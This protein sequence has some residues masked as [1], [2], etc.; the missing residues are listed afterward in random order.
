MLQ[1]P[2]AQRLA[3]LEAVERRQQQSN[4]R[5]QAGRTTEQKRDLARSN[6]RVFDKTEDDQ[7]WAAVGARVASAPAREDSGRL[8]LPET[9]DVPMRNES[10][11][12]VLSHGS[13]DD[14]DDEQ[15]SEISL[16]VELAVRE[17]VEAATYASLSF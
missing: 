6:I 8:N 9:A 15:R 4:A 7:S 10:A 5:G 12:S 17:M 1:G 16:I 14:D 13:R 3:A 11:D 2:N